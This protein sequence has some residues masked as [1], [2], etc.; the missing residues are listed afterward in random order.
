VLLTTNYLEEADALCDR[1]AVIDRGRLAALDTPAELK[2]SY[3][4][5]LIEIEL[6]SELSSEVA[7]RL[8]RLRG[9]ANVVA[10]GAT[11]RMALATSTNHGDRA[12]PAGV[13]V[14]EALAMLSQAGWETRRLNL[15]EPSLDEVFLALTGKQVRD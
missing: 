9:V 10:D 3:G 13:V 15:R 7:E 2:N 8:K 1:I 6:D 14:P 4:S 5:G 11:V 12:V